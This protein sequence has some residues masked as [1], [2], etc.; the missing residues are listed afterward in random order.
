M[1]REMPRRQ[2]MQDLAAMAPAALATTTMA[3]RSRTEART[4]AATHRSRPEALRNR[5]L[6]TVPWAGIDAHDRVR[7]HSASG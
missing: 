7:R 2:A 1:P 4:G 6:H 5:H 3:A